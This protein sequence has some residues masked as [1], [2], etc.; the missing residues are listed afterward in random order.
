[1]ESSLKI[2]LGSEIQSSIDDKLFS[3]TKYV[4]SSEL[5]KFY[6]NEFNL[7]S[8]TIKKDN[9]WSL[10]VPEKL[11]LN[12][13][14]VGLDDQA[15]AHESIDHVYNNKGMTSIRIKG[16]DR[17]ILFSY[18]YSINNL[19]LIVFTFFVLLILYFW[20]YKRFFN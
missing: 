3:D 12:Y 18:Q 13:V 14:Q 1:M 16:I 8:P 15:L 5:I 20:S 11:H 9:L 10:V 7:N 2:Q 4:T 17:K 19:F 6:V